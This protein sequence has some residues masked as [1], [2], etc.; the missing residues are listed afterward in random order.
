MLGHRPSLRRA[1][2]G[3][4]CL[5]AGCQ[6]PAPEPR[7]VRSP[8]THPDLP[9]AASSVQ[10]GGLSKDAED[11]S[12]ALAH[13]IAGL[14]HLTK[15]ET[16][17]ALDEWR[18]VVIL[19]P[20]RSDLRERVVQEF[21]RR[22]EFGHAAEVLRVAVQKLPDS[23]ADWMLLAVALRADKQWDAATEAA[24]HAI[25]LDPDKFPSYEVLFDVAVERN[26]LA[27]AKKVLERAARHPSG[28]YH[29]WIRL[30]ELC[31]ALGARDPA[32]KT[33]PE[34]VT[35][36]YD[37][38]AELQPSDPT[39]LARVADYYVA[40]KH[41]EKAIAIYQK[42]LDQDPAADGIRLKLALSHV[43][44]G[45]KA[46]AIAILE[47]M[48]R[49]EPLRW[50][51]FNLIGELYED[52][53]DNENA[54]KNYA[55]ALR[56]NPNQLPPYL[57]S[58]LIQMRARK[59]DEALALL[60]AAREKFPDTPQI[61]YFYGL[62]YSD[63]KDFPSALKFLEE[64][65]RLASASNPEILDA[66]FHFYLGAAL[67]RNGK[68]DAAVE[69]F[70]KAIDQNPDYADACNYLGYLFAERGV[71][72][73]EAQHL[74]QHALT[75]EPNNGAFLDSLGWIYYRL[76]QFPEALTHLQ[77]AAALIPNDPVIHEHLGEIHRA[78]GDAAQ[79]LAHFQKAAELDPKNSEMAEKVEA[80][81]REISA[82]PTPAATP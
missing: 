23:A 21:F 42:V 6:T 16:T 7:S 77:Q 46:N 62:V 33:D 35:G 63:R 32:F 59:L 48:V 28:E 75:I 18:Q 13:Y 14:I 30:A 82:R 66:V 4:F 25:R 12:E 64:T 54:L 72:L 50:Q 3:L 71:N 36:F 65:A 56:A 40:N 52:A 22:G 41:T 19:D 79:A 70:R 81:K 61:S 67:E 27:R 10:L 49:R 24:E 51:I 43:A 37:R 38:T 29:Y 34:R 76:K 20:A 15:G 31:T 5:V 55:L 45:N 17:D 60:D 74:V 69:K 9:E 47:E 80:L 73:E 2:V 68:F 44:Q 53:K 26:D 39:V 78:L 58:V 1:V 8:P 57:R 11:F